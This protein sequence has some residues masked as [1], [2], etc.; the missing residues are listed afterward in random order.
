MKIL[1]SLL[2]ATLLVCPAYASFISTAPGASAVTTNEALPGVTSDGETVDFFSSLMKITDEGDRTRFLGDNFEFFNAAGTRAGLYMHFNAAHPQ[3]TTLGADMWFEPGTGGALAGGIA[4]YPGQNCDFG[5]SNY[6]QGELP[7]FHQWRHMAFSGTMFFVPPSERAS[8]TTAST[9]VLQLIRGGTVASG[10][11]TL[12]LKNV[13][14]FNWVSQDQSR[15]I[16]HYLGASGIFKTQQNMDMWV[17][18]AKFVSYSSTAAKAR[19][20]DATLS[21]GTVTVT[22]TNNDANDKLFLQ[23]KTPGGTLCNGVKTSISAGANFTITS[24][25]ADGT[26][27]TTDTSTYSWWLLNKQ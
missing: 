8:H 19:T 21:S 14:S 9:T 13:S 24:V 6:Q 4:C 20:G 25:Q 17:N 18:D 2:F 16:E 26:T 1:A 7:G 3:L 23:L 22:N 12:Q 15:Y 11:Q 10:Q 27:C 5:Y